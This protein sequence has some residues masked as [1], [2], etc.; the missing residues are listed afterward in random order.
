MFTKKHDYYDDY[1]ANFGNTILVLKWNGFNVPVT[2]ECLISRHHI[3]GRIVLYSDIK[4]GQTTKIHDCSHRLDYIKP[5][6]DEFNRQIQQMYEPG[7]QKYL[8]AEQK[9]LT[10]T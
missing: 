7:G 4:N 3:H 2:G 5:C 1:Y 9:I 10:L 8:Q 6:V